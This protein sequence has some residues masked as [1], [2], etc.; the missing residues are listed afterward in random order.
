MHRRIIVVG[1]G[2]F[3][4]ALA[5]TLT[6]QGCDVVAVDTNM[7]SIEAIKRRV[8]FA[9]QLDATDPE[10]LRAVDAH[11]CTGAVVAIGEMFEAAVLCVAALREVGVPHVVARARTDRQARILAVVGAAEVVQLEAEMGRTAALRLATAPAPG[12]PPR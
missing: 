7:A 6:D 4:T 3:G 5:T 1:L 10:A 12:P 11:T 2:Q 8:A 9:V